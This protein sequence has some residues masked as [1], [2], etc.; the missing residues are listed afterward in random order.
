[1]VLQRTVRE[2]E[3]ERQRKRKNERK[4]KKRRMCVCVCEREREREFIMIN[5]KN[6]NLLRRH[7]VFTMVLPGSSSRFLFPR[8]IVNFIFTT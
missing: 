5:S 1:M 4:R 8:F 2:R 3:R 6:V 7:F